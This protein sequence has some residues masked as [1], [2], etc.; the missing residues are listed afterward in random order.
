MASL[1]GNKIKDT[2]S[3]L[4]KL[5]SSSASATEQ[6]VEDGAG[7][8]TAL[9]LSTDTVETT[10]DLKISGTPAAA[11]SEDVTALMLGPSGVVVTRNLSTSPI[12]TASIT[13]NSPIVATGSTVGLDDPANLSALTSSTTAN[14]DKFLIWDESLSEYKSISASELTGYMGSNVAAQQSVFVARLQADTDVPTSTL[15][16]SFA[17]IYGDT[18]ATGSTT[19]ASSCL[20]YGSASSDI[21]FGAVTNPRDV[22]L[23]FSNSVYTVD[24]SLEMVCS[25]PN[26]SV[27]ISL[28]KTS[29]P[30]IELQ[31]YRNLAAGTYT[32]SFFKS[33]FMQTGSSYQIQV[34]ASGSGIQITKNST[35]TLTNLGTVNSS[36]SPA[37]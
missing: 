6:I 30:T 22:F 37:G 26:T 20:T 9:K 4:L 21:S 25:S 5:A 32:A 7:T 18:S 14:N 17:E 35:V 12:G 16:I 13:A 24:I 2:Y 8:S 34:V 10:G 19:L 29:G 27:T 28:V 3:L 1:S 11:T 33:V 31:S 15:A 36:F 23:I